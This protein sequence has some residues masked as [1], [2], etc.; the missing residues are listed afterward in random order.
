MLISMLIWIVFSSLVTAGL[1]VWDKRM[2]VEDRVRISERTLLVWCLIGGWPGGWMVAHRI[3]HKTRKQSF[4]IK[5]SGCVLI[6]VVT[7]IGILLW[8]R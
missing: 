1:Y 4:R 7:V 2:A 5:F 6:N 3:R 8:G